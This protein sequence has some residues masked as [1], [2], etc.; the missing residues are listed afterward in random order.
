MSSNDN[1]TSEKQRYKVIQEYRDFYLAESEKGYKECFNKTQYHPT[2]DGCIIKTLKEN[3]YTGGMAL[4]P[5]KVNRSFVGSKKL[6]DLWKEEQK[7]I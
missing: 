7:L 4:P 5:D 1:S 2:E 6:E 3:N